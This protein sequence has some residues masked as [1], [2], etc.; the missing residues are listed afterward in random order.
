MGMRPYS[1]APYSVSE[2]A[3]A[4]ESKLSQ[5]RCTVPQK[6]AGKQKSHAEAAL[7]VEP[8]EDAPIVD[9]NCGAAAA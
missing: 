7:H 1:G 4:G 8:H 5:R 2:A 3:D 6:A 9:L